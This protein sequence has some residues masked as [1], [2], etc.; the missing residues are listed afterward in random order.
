MGVERLTTI[1]DWPILPL[2]QFHFAYFATLLFG[3]Y[4]FSI[5]VLLVNWP[6]YHYVVICHYTATLHFLKVCIMLLHFYE[7]STLIHAS[8]NLKKS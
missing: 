2:Y 5:V 8:I 7:T 3:V 6:F 4:T 1:V